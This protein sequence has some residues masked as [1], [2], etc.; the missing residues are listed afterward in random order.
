MLSAMS[1]SLEYC[2]PERSEGSEKHH[3]RGPRSFPFVPQ[4]CGSRAQDDI[5]RLRMTSVGFRMTSE[6]A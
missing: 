4:G 6:E 3:S 2:H 1:R 5:D